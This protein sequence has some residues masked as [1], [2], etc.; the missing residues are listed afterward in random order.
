MILKHVLP[1]NDLRDHEAVR[2]CWCEPT[3]EVDRPDVI[4]HHSADHR[5]QVGE[6]EPWRV[7]L[8]EVYA[9]TKEG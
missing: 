1:L 8:E 6:G 4:V 5:E 7:V 3:P 9:S 2:D